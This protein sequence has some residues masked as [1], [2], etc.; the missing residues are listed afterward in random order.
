MPPPASHTSFHGR[1]HCGDVAFTLD[2]PDP[3]HPLPVRA[4]GCGYCSRLGGLWTS[5]PHGH[6]VVRLAR[7][8][9]VTRYRF[10]HGTAEFFVCRTCGIVPL[11]TSAT[12]ERLL[13]VVNANTFEDLTPDALSITP[14]DFEG[15]DRDGRLARRERNWTPTDIVT[16]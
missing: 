8:E 9:G 11:A 14:T 4:C 5:A 3:P 1:C 10:G 16:G 12:G 6:L 7:A 2:W 13:A 15:E